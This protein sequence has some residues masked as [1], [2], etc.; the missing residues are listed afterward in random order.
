MVFHKLRIR[1]E[2]GDIRYQGLL[3]G[4]VKGWDFSFD[5]EDPEVI[6]NS[7]FFNRMWY[8]HGKWVTLEL[9]S[10]GKG[11]WKIMARPT[12]RPQVGK[13]MNSRLIFETKEPLKFV[14]GE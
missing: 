4:Q 8:E 5:E 12:G 10:A 1:G 13:L 3:V 14:K 6:V 2:K 9:S 7:Y 11:Y